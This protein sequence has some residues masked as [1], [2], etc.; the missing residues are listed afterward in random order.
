ML[1]RTRN[2]VTTLEIY[3]RSKTF[4]FISFVF[5]DIGVLSHYR[6]YSVPNRLFKMYHRKIYWCSMAMHSMLSNFALI[7]YQLKYSTNLLFE[8]AAAPNFGSIW[9]FSRKCKI[10]Q[11]FLILILSL[12]M[13]KSMAAA[14]ANT[15]WMNIRTDEGDLRAI[16]ASLELRRS[17][18]GVVLLAKTTSSQ[19]IV[20]IILPIGF[21]KSFEPGQRRV[22]VPSNSP[23]E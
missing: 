6:Q 23:V 10:F 1:P 5:R 19:L 18:S 9:L 11:D 14:P 2:S 21:Y 20:A 4:C 13:S 7:R 22:H 12:T 8:L 15:K 17:C 3:N 16:W